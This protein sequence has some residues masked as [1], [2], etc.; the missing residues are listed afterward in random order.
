MSV[1]AAT[2]TAAG[3]ALVLLGVVIAAAALIDRRRE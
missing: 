3:L 2:L 1:I